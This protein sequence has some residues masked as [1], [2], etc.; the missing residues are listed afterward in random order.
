MKKKFLVS[1]LCAMLVT[2]CS[3]V[4]QANSIIGGDVK[5]EE[6][7]NEAE[8]TGTDGEGAETATATDSKGVYE[9]FLKNEI[10]VHIDTEG[11]A[12][13]YIFQRN[14]EEDVVTFQELVQTLVESVQNN[15]GGA[16]VDMKSVGI[17]YAYIDCGNDGAEEL[18][19]E[20][21]IPTNVEETVEYFVIKDN[22]GPLE[23]VYT[24]EGWSR[25]N[26]HINRFGYVY[27]DGSGGANTGSYGKGFIGADGKWHYI[28]TAVATTF[29]SGE[30]L[31]F[32]GDLHTAPSVGDK[33]Y[34][35][36]DFD[37]NDT[38]NEEVDDTFSYAEIG[39][40]ASTDPSEGYRGFFCAD[41][42]VDD[43]LYEDSNALKKFFTDAGL[44]TVSI[45]D[46][47]K[48]IEEKENEEGLTSEIKDGEETPWQKLEVSF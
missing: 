10:T 1:V 12:G 24:D 18:A 7:S 28:Y 22:D 3:S 5:V 46:I 11:D 2:G 29:T 33:K 16:K 42:L 44:T 35:F 47:T 37:F 39:D 32:N 4:P 19:L 17:R 25:S 21:R 9:S 15:N 40:I 31:S 48:M 36:F 26:I 27:T 6:G 14:Y 30:D 34:V 13:Y 8:E 38:I 41:L 23:V 20:I 43:S 45:T